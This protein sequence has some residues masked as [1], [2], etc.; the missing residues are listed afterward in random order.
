[1]TREILRDGY[2]WLMNQLYSPASYFT[3]L[4][5][6]L[7][8]DHFQLAR[9]QSLYWRRHAWAGI[10]GR[11]LLF[12]RATFLFAHLICRIHDAALRR[13]YL[14]RIVGVLRRR[15]DLAIFEGYVVKCAMHYHHY[16]MAREMAGGVQPVLNFY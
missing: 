3:R 10:K 1:M 9:R 6:L 16:R 15:R 13:E 11:L 5:G 4:D 14:R 8:D 7:L 2:I 12:M